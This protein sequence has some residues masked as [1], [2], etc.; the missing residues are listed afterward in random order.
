MNGSKTYFINNI[1]FC[2]ALQAENARL[3]FFAPLGILIPAKEKGVVTMIEQD[4]IKLLRECDAGTKMGISSIEDVLEHVKK[5]DFRKKLT[6]CRQEHQD[7]QVKILQEL[8]KYKDDGKDPNPIAKGMSW[9]KTNMKLSMEESDATIAELMTDGCNMGVKSLNRYL[10]Q[11]KAADE[12]SKDMAK[13]LINLEEKL[14]VDIRQY[15]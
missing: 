2:A 8:E 3:I 15:L 1:I 5:E 13:R 11:Y 14:A 10:N 12:I 6:K 9:M 7:L 4:T